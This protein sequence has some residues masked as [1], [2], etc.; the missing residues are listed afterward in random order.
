MKPTVR[1]ISSTAAEPRHELAARC[2]RLT[3]QWL[4][5]R[6]D[7]RRLHDAPTKDLPALRAAALRLD[8]LER[9]R[10]ALLRDLRTLA[11]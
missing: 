1:A 4:A 5:A 3:R 6:A 11:G 9:S 8:Q 10:S 7:Y 2:E